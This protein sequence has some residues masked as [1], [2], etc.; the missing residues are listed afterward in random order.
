MHLMDVP[1]MRILHESGE[2]EE[3]SYRADFAEFPFGRPPPKPVRGRVM[4]VA[5]GPLPAEFAG[6]PY[7]IGRLNLDEYILIVPERMVTYLP[8]RAMAATLVVPE[9]T[10][11]LQRRYLYPGTIIIAN[12]GYPLGDVMFIHPDVADRLLAG[13]G[14][15][16]ESLNQAGESL[17]PGG[18]GLTDPGAEVELELHVEV[19]EAMEEKYYNVIGYIAGEGSEMGMDDDVIMV[20]AYYDGLGMG[21]EG[22]LYP[23]ANDNLSAVA[24][25]LELARVL[26]EGPYTPDKTI[27][28]VAW[29]GG[30]RWEGFSVV[31]AMSAKIG[32]NLLNVEAVLELTG[33]GGGSGE[34]ISLG[35]GT[36]FRLTQLIEA[37]ASRMGVRVTT[38]GTDPHFGLPTSI[39]HGTRD[40]LS[41]FIS[42]DGSDQ[43]AHLPIDD[44]SRVESEKM[45]DLGRT[46]ALVLTVLSREVEY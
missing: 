9:S 30:E 23:G 36:S 45:E 35:A 43:L 24:V 5:A 46:L 10:E 40:A 41:A 11:R 2:V 1:E 33:V 28:F 14:A 22:V 12:F 16:V 6:D 7:G 26:K 27:V 37:A 18:V 3:L 29:S 44:L 38:R 4:G 32:F 15:T 42:W 34:A 39:G 13:T 31:D 17:P 21:P 19:G 20:S 8:G 25:M